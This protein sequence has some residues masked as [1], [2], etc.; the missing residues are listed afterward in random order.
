MAPERGRPARIGICAARQSKVAFVEKCGRG[1]PRSGA[2][3][4]ATCVAVMNSVRGR[5]F[6]CAP[7]FFDML[8]EPDTHPVPTNADPDAR[9]ARGAFFPPLIL[10]LIPGDNS[11]AIQECTDEFCCRFGYVLRN[12]AD[13]IDRP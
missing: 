5:N 10:P 7:L 11:P 8:V 3:V 12:P 13:G 4:S 1:R 2:I 6:P 9:G